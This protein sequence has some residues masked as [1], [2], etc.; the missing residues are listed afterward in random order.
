MVY[1]I[2]HSANKDQDVTEYMAALAIVKLRY[3]NNLPALQSPLYNVR[4]TLALNSINL[5]LY[6][7]LRLTEDKLDT[8]RYLD[9][10]AV[11]S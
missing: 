7:G 10:C 9:S 6:A 3:R 8:D 5:N 4:P 11:H 1:K 2:F